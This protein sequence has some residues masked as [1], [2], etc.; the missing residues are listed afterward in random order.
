MNKLII[1]TMF[2]RETTVTN[3]AVSYYLHIYRSNEQTFL[4]EFGPYKLKQILFAST[5]ST[6]KAK[7]RLVLAGRSYVIHFM[8]GL[9]MIL[10]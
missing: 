9:E 3:C 8:H 1:K 5:Q 4:N 6:L 2:T 7:N 10:K